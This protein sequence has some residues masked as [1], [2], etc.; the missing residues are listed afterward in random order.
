MR[1]LDLPLDSVLESLCYLDFHDL[2]ASSVASASTRSLCS[3]LFFPLLE[4]K[5]PREAAE[6]KAQAGSGEPLEGAARRRLALESKL[7]RLAEYPAFVSRVSLGLLRFRSRVSR[8]VLEPSAY[9]MFLRVW[10]G[11]NVAWEATVPCERVEHYT[12]IAPVMPKL[13]PSTM[14][15]PDCWEF[16]RGRWCYT[17]DEEGN[18]FTEEDN[19]RMIRKVDRNFKISILLV[20]PEDRKVAHLV[21]KATMAWCDGDENEPDSAFT[22][23]D[24]GLLIHVSVKM[25]FDTERPR[26]GPFHV[27]PSIA[28]SELVS[29]SGGE[30]LSE[31]EF[32]RLISGLE[33]H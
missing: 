33:W 32:D 23:R 28:L 4:R 16:L 26:V 9:S 30:E 17:E 19:S 25:L 2:G 7:R 15:H 21:T 22:F 11:A 27:Y 3:N 8:V 14:D 10:D 24:A 31:L 29:E 1:L 6:E 18:A 20:R 5:F 13:V 12:A